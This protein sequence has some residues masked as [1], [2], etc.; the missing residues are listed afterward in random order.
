MSYKLKIGKDI[1]Q[2]G[3]ITV[4]TS[5]TFQDS[6]Y[7]KI[8]MVDAAITLTIPSTGL[9]DGWYI[10]LDVLSTG[11]L[12]IADDAGGVVLDFPAGK[13]LNADKMGTVYRKGTVNAYR[14]KG[15]FTV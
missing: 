6:D 10:D 5:R 12:T 4:S 2:A 1:E 9:R 11:T 3:V 7:G 14:G 15:E 13:I 8:I